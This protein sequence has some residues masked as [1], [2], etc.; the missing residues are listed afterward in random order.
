MPGFL[1]GEFGYLYLKVWL[2]M[3][4]LFK[5]V[6][7]CFVFNNHHFFSFGD[8]L[9]FCRDFC[10]WDSWRTDG[11]VGTIINQ[12]HIIKN[13]R[14]AHL[15]VARHLL[16]FERIPFRDNI[17]LATGLDYRKFLCFCRCCFGCH[18]SKNYTK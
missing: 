2:A 3:A 11:G 4:A 17:L 1:L 6:A 13:N 15:V 18:N 9:N 5:I 8:F 12:Q 14:V 16:D 10:T 7:L